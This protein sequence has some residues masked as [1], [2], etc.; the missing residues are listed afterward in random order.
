MTAEF[1]WVP[2]Q[3][4]AAAG[5][6]TAWTHDN[7][8]ATSGRPT[9][10]T[11]SPLASPELSP[12][13]ISASPSRSSGGAR[14][15]QSLLECDYDVNPTYLYQA[16]EARQWDH[17]KQMMTH[18]K[19]TISTQASTWVVRKETSGKLRW[20]ILPIH[21]SIIFQAPLEIVEL[22]LQEYP[23]G[24]QC[25]DDQGMLPLHLAFRND[26]T[27]DVMEELVTAYPNGI[28][29]KDRK[30]RTP[31]ACASSL[32][33]KKA[34]VLELYSQIAISTERQRGLVESRAVLEA[35]TEALQD[36][37]A[38]SLIRLKSDLGHE[39]D[40]LVSALAAATMELETTKTKLDQSTL[41]LNEKV[42]TEVALTQKLGQ[43]TSALNT[44]N[45][46]R[47]QEETVEQHKLVKREKLL[48]DANTELV[49]LVQSL[50][51]QQLSLKAQL[52]DQVWKAKE[53]DD[54]RAKALEEYSKRHL[55]AEGQSRDQRNAWC[56]MLQDS[57]NKATATLNNVV[58]KTT[59]TAIPAEIMADGAVFS[60]SI[61][62]APSDI[63]I[64]VAARQG[65]PPA[66]VP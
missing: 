25:K 21:A 17:V 66:Y 62:T 6:M 32:G 65:D 27:W 46:A 48:T 61:F 52:N 2:P 35:R 30:G 20:R 18:D 23:M 50:L 47:R 36:V 54:A 44:V 9:N 57:C 40:Q 59:G 53:A 60:G 4:T 8:L 26:A 24:A 43:V 34:S 55:E 45:E 12:S 14:L 38:K 49:A 28:S 1:D 33:K 42:A 51:D 10:G 41:Q 13:S 15:G 19:N 11:A 63:H 22:L 39:R 37:H 3:P 16:I 58:A 7:T 5:D 29:V 56:A 64:Q 31:T